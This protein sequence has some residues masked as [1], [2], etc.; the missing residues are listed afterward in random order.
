MTTYPAIEPDAYRW[1]QKGSQ[2]WIYD[3]TPKWLEEHRHEVDV[4]PLYGSNVVGELRSQLAE[5]QQAA[6]VEAGLRR[7]FLARAEKAEAERDDALKQLVTVRGVVIIE[8]M[9][10]IDNLRMSGACLFDAK[11]SGQRGVD[12]ADALFDAHQ[13]LRKLCTQTDDL[14]GAEK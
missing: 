5:W 1:R 12:R 9:S 4:E 13:E 10:A 14:H 8:C 6:S 2:L 3:P 11:H 7:E